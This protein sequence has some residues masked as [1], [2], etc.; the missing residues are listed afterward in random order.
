[1]PRVLDYSS[2]SDSLS[3]GGSSP[4]VELADSL[5][6]SAEDSS[7]SVEL[8][9]SLELSAGDSSPSV[10]LADSLEL[11]AGAEDSVDV[12]PVS[13]SPQP[14]TLTLLRNARASTSVPGAAINLETNTISLSPVFCDLICPPL[15]NDGEPG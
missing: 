14:T 6:L 2:V 5:E 13:G 10:E 9:D 3:A 11:S 1:M 8:A 4:S 15:G 12:P 7:P